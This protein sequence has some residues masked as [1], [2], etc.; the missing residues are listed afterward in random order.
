MRSIVR[1]SFA[2]TTGAL[3][4]TI[5]ALDVLMPTIM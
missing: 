4:A 1:D 5:Q 3:I 2:R